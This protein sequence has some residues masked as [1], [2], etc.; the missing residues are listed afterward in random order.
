MKRAVHAMRPGRMLVLMLAGA[1]WLAA[2]NARAATVETL[3]DPRL[4][5]TVDGRALPVRIAEMM[6]A[7]ARLGSRDV[8]FNRT[9]DAL[10]E[11]Q[12]LARDALRVHGR[13]KLM[14]ADR[15]GFA[16][17]VTLEQQYTTLLKQAYFKPMDAFVKA[18]PG[19]R[20]DALVSW[21][22]P[23]SDPALRELMT[24]R[25]RGEVR[26]TP[27]QVA[28][29]AK[30]VVARITLPDGSVRD[31]TFA[32]L[33]ER[34]NVQGRVQWLQEKDL[35]FLANQ[36][37][38]RAETLFVD[39]WAGKHSGLT[40]AD[41]ALLRTLLEEK[42][43]RDRYLF[44]LGVVSVIHEDTPPFLARLERSVTP[45]EIRAWY[46]KNREQFRQVEKV[47]ARHIRCATEQA[48]A[49]AHRAVSSGMD[50]GTA[51][52]RWSI[53]PSRAAN[54]PGDLGWLVRTDPKLP[55]I[56]QIALIQQRGQMSA[57]IRTPEDAGGNAS[58]EIVR[59]D[60]RVEGYSPPESETVAYLGRQEIARRKA[61]EHYQQLRLRLREQADIRI[62]STLRR[63]RH[64]AVDDAPMAEPEPA[65]DHGH[66]HGH[67]H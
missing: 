18:L 15:V 4:A 2:E 13:D 45:A 35:R 37:D 60:E 34:M 27:G 6:M 48:C 33:Y 40:A 44:E 38:A 19:A 47:R 59:V 3:A 54:P 64:T 23:A 31:V 66:S 30:T 1:T 43:L 42:H 61:A 51:V 55:W 52:R 11:N 56:G 63:A 14:Q 32:E 67:R 7:T 49:E 10:V 50:F 8:T 53:A 17:A 24:L 57:P 16:P 9:V 28:L 39:W 65:D 20:L 21:R 22:M 26:L 29:A 5:V 41:L 12:L 58:W 62:N 46:A 36:V 25:H